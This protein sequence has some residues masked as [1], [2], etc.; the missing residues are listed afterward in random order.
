[1]PSQAGR[2]AV[3]PGANTGIGFE[4]ARVLAARGAT[5]VLA[6]HDVA[7]QRRLWAESER[8][9]GVTYPV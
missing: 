3:V 5:V 8:L 9:T 1:M 7:L 4:A 2:I 6:C